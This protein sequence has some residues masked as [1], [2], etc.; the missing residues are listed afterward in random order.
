MKIGA[1]SFSNLALL[2]SSLVFHSVGAVEW[3]SRGGSW[4]FGSPL[5]VQWNPCL[6][7]LS[8]SPV[9]IAVSRKEA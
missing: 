6:E 1:R 9:D 8:V 5:G 2:Y 3:T 4:S 7:S